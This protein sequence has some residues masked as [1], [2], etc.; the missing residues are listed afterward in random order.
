MT[1]YN[2]YYKAGPP[3]LN[4]TRPRPPSR[5]PLPIY[6]VV[7]LVVILVKTLSR[8]A[9]KFLVALFMTILYL[10]NLEGVGLLSITNQVTMCFFKDVGF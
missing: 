4:T 5:L 8:P 9:L 10:S 2:L 1:T 6:L 7:I 3:P